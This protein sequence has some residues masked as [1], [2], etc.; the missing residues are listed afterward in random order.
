MRIISYSKKYYLQNAQRNPDLLWNDL[1]S[2]LFVQQK[3]YNSAFRQEKAIFKRT[4]GNTIQR[5]VALGKLALEDNDLVMAKA[6]Y[7]YVV[8]KTFDS[9]IRLNAQL[10]LI[11]IELL[12]ATKEQWDDI[13]VKFETL[14]EV[15][16]YKRETLQLQVA[17]A[18]FLTFKKDNPK[19]AINI[20]KKCLELPLNPRGRAYVKLALGDISGV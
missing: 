15:H 2:W 14:I 17:Y 11:D 9:V 8:D 1:L 4:E 16:G 3:Q 5:L 7:E 20:L 12:E 6:I 10:N 13:Q 18:N 19:P